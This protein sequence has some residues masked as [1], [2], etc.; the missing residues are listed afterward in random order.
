MSELSK[1]GA[2]TSDLHRD[3]IP[4]LAMQ[5]IQIPKPKD[6]QTFQR[7]CVTLFALVLNDPLLMQEYGRSGENQG[8]IDLL[9][10]RNSNPNHY[11]GIQCRLITKAMSKETVLSDCRKAL[12]LPFNLREIVFATSLPDSVSLTKLA[13]T[14]EQILRREGRQVS[15]AILGWNSLE[16]LIARHQQAF[17]VF[18][19]IPGAKT[20]SIA[21]ERLQAAIAQME[22]S[23]S[24][25]NDILEELTAQASRETSIPFETVQKVFADSGF[26]AN[27]PVEAIA[28]VSNLLKQIAELRQDRSRNTDGDGNADSLAQASLKAGDLEGYVAN[29]SESLAQEQNAHKEIVAG[30]FQLIMKLAKAKRVQSKFDEAIQLLQ[31][32]IALFSSRDDHPSESYTARWQIAETKYEK[33]RRYKDIGTLQESLALLDDL[34]NDTYARTL[35]FLRS[36]IIVNRFEI[37][38]QILFKQYRYDDLHT[39]ISD[40]EPAVT[41]ALAGFNEDLF[42]VRTKVWDGVFTAGSWTD[43]VKVLLTALRLANT[44]HTGQGNPIRRK[45]S[46]RSRENPTTFSR[47]VLTSSRLI[48]NLLALYRADQTR[49]EPYMHRALALASSLQRRVCVFG[50]PRLEIG[51][52][53]V[54]AR[55]L[56]VCATCS[57]QLEWARF[58]LDLLVRYEPEKR[59]E[60]YLAGVPSLEMIKARINLHFWHKLSST[61]QLEEIAKFEEMYNSADAE[62]DPLELA[63]ILELCG[64]SYRNA[65]ILDGKPCFNDA[66]TAYLRALVLL[67]PAYEVSPIFLGRMVRRINNKALTL[68]PS[69]YLTESDA[70]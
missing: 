11:V 6:W 20:S 44:I 35:D 36:R 7:N 53:K 59:D 70:I 45:R 24:K 18:M 51:S 61:K 43:D 32:G 4:I 66:S 33:G 62:Q 14:I 48:L 21:D 46:E 47:F 63:D 25:M 2:T 5:S 28:A 12:R 8:G 55:A 42:Q 65:A 9:G 1:G 49:F 13:Y 54:W 37:K 31:Q 10:R 3:R 34:E 19:P 30:Q 58:A 39:I 57:R 41:L 29:L 67:Q 68:P 23:Q 69:A 50:T 56:D 16:N 40:L 22:A 38:K 52:I 26:V 17:D 64:D 15:V 27:T 60:E